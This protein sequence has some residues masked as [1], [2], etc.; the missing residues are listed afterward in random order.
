VVG[1][2]NGDGNPDLA[3]ANYLSKTVSVLL[4]AG[5]GSFNSANA[6]DVGGRPQSVA[7]ADFNGD[8]VLDLVT[9]DFSFPTVSLLLGSGDGSFQPSVGFLVGF[10]PY[11]VVAGDLNAD[12]RAD[13]AV[14]NFHPTGT[15]TILLNAGDWGGPAPPLKREHDGKASG[16]HRRLGLDV[17]VQLF[18]AGDSPYVQPFGPTCMALRAR[19]VSPLP[20][21]PE[22]QCSKTTLGRGVPTR[23]L[24]PWHIAAVARNHAD[25]PARLLWLDLASLDHVGSMKSNVVSISAR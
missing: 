12:G 9:G 18:G 15:M 8:R 22:L 16:P 21:E 20:L 19:V 7:V 25:W 4:G 1:D 17:R 10:Q 13:L 2:F 14:A 6:Y 11:G 23:D 3:I 24:T 5:G